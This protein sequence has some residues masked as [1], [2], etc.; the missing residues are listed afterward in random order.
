M[1]RSYGIRIWSSRLVWLSR[2]ASHHLFLSSE[3]CLCDSLFWAFFKKQ[4][5]ARLHYKVHKN[6]YLKKL[7]FLQASKS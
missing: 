7:S 4:I 1:L 6:I 3:H 2:S 5:Q